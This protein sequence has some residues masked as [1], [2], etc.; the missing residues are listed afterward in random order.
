MNF[1][2]SYLPTLDI[3]VQP[4]K[5]GIHISTKFSFIEIM[6]EMITVKIGMKK[7]ANEINLSLFDIINKMYDIKSIIIAYSSSSYTLY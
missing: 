6:Y 3:E 7:Q 5:I 4:S 1:T 2:G